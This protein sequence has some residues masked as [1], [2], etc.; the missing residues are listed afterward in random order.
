M[1]VIAAG[2]TDGRECLVGN[3]VKRK[4]KNRRVWQVQDGWKESGSKGKLESSGEHGMGHKESLHRRRGGVVALT[5]MKREG[6]SQ[7]GGNRQ[8]AGLRR[9]LNVWAKRRKGSMVGLSHGEKV[10]VERE[11]EQRHEDEKRAC[12]EAVYNSLIEEIQHAQ[13]GAGLTTLNYTAT[14]VPAN[15]DKA[16]WNLLLFL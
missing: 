3:G 14:S 8:E 7:Q 13:C 1:V 12:P 16:I 4:V 6:E 11:N 9:S 10:K 2:V 5:V 15:A